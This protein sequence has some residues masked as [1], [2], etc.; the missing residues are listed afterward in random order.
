MKMHSVARSK[1]V[2]EG[3][4]ARDFVGPAN[5]L[6]KIEREKRPA[7]LNIEAIHGVPETAAQ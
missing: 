2:Y 4:V 3:E 1:L 5:D 6:A 7:E